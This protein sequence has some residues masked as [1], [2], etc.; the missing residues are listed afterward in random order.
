MYTTVGGSMWRIFVALFYW[1]WLALTSSKKYRMVAQ[2]PN[3]SLK[4]MN[5]TFEAGKIKP[6]IDGP[7][8]FSNIIDA[9][10]HF[11]TARHK[12]KVIVT[13]GD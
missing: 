12:G 11:E 9:L 13:M 4:L 8:K 1:P 7:Y 6:I 5:E 10:K 2:K 3:K